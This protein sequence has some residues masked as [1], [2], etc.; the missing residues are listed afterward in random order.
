M[1]HGPHSLVFYLLQ[2]LNPLGCRIWTVTRWDL[3]SPWT[4]ISGLVC[5]GLP[6]LGLLKWK[7]PPEMQ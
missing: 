1:S 6:R 2:L 4:Q 5:E 3:E 7:G